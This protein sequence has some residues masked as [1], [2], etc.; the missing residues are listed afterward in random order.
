MFNAFQQSDITSWIAWLILFTILV[1]FSRSLEYYRLLLEVKKFIDQMNYSV[2]AAF[3]DVFNTLKS[4]ARRF[5]VDAADPFLRGKML[6]VADSVVISPT[7]LDPFG[8]VE[9]Y[10]HILTSADRY[11][12]EEV[13]SIFKGKAPR[14]VVENARTLLEILRV[15]TL[16]LKMVKHYYITARRYKSYM[17]LF[18]LRYLLP[19]ILEAIETLKRALTAFAKGVPVG[20]SV[21]PLTAF[22]LYLRFK[23]V[24]PFR[25]IVEDTVAAETEFEGRRV[26]IVKA[27]GP[28]SNVGRLDDALEKIF[29]L[30]DPKAVIT[31]DAALKLEGEI[32]G[33]VAEGIGVAI[34]G[35]GVEKFNIEKIATSRRVP[36]YAVVIKMSEEEAITALRDYLDRAVELA[37]RTVER[38]ILRYTNKGDT[39]VVVGVGNTVGVG[40]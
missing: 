20:D 7:D 30:Y 40:Q 27:R 1:L 19:Q 31:V 14:E 34:G 26:I 37:V 4:I 29:N 3:N 33:S 2:N 36:L 23:K 24:T 10:K 12:L 25:E 18:Q 5:G 11:L 32:S 39:V 28:G 9:K 16:Y 6:R 21:G 8:I 38:I 15:M 35:I 13:S 17:L 22:R